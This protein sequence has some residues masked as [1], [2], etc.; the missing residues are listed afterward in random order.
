MSKSGNGKDG[1]GANK[2]IP[3]NKD[4]LDDSKWKGTPGA[5]GDK[6]GS[7]RNNGGKK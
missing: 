6:L 7:D 3:L 4:V 5:A 2:G 1:K